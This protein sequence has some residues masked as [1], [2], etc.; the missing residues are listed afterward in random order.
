MEI[1]TR[2]YLGAPTD[3]T[4]VTLTVHISTCC[5]VD[6]IISSLQEAKKLLQEETYS[7]AN[8]LCNIE[9]GELMLENKYYRDKTEEEKQREQM[10]A[11]IQE[12][13]DRKL[14]IELKKRFK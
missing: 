5:S 10:R 9:D 14:Y 8:I 1:K 3:K 4:L 6:G 12:E 11:S 13:C 7:E 2:T